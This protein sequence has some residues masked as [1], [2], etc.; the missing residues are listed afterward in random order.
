MS[1]EQL[2]RLIR[3]DRRERF[4]DYSIGATIM[5]I[6][7]AVATLAVPLFPV[8]LNPPPV[9]VL[10][11]KIN[12]DMPVCPGDSVEFVSRIEV[13]E[14]SIIGIYTA[15]RDDTENNILFAT[16]RALPPVPRPSK[17][18]IHE[19]VTFTV[20]DLPPGPY[21]RIAAFASLNSDTKPS[22]LLVPFEVDSHCG[23]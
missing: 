17:A 21:T 16:Q 7:M 11:V 2:N 5:L 14:P 13:H 9:E 20:P 6:I 15:I 1:E 12:T 18:T 22:Y 19:T 10:G 4:I 23:H 3:R 8:A